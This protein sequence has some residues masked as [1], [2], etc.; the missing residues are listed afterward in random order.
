MLVISVCNRLSALDR[1]ARLRNTFPQ[2]GRVVSRQDIYA[3]QGALASVHFGVFT[4]LLLLSADLFAGEFP[5]YEIFS[6]SEFQ[7]NAAIYV[8][9]GWGFPLGSVLPHEQAE[10]GTEQEGQSACA[11]AQSVASFRSWARS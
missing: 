1:T 7:G 8:G 5:R 4:A 11:H 2:P 6:G 9:G 3:Q 10:N